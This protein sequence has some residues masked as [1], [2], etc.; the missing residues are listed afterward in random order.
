M[1][2]VAYNS[3]LKNGLFSIL[4]GSY[5]STSNVNMLSYRTWNPVIS[6]TV[7]LNWAVYRDFYTTANSSAVRL[8]LKIN[9]IIVSSERINDNAPNTRSQIPRTFQNVDFTFP[10]FIAKPGH[11]YQA[12]LELL[13]SPIK[14]GTAY[15]ARGNLYYD[16]SV[17]RNKYRFRYDNPHIRNIN[18]GI[19][20]I[21]DSDYWYGGIT[22]HAPPNEQDDPCKMVYREGLW[23]L[24]TPDEYNSLIG[25]TDPKVIRRNQLRNEGWYISWDNASNIGAPR[26]PHGHLI[27]TALGNKDANGYLQMFDYK[28]GNTVTTTWWPFGERPEYGDT[29]YFRTSGINNYFVMNYRRSTGNTNLRLLVSTNR[30]NIA[31][32]IRCVR[33]VAP[34]LS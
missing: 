30:N 22:P 21:G 15:W 34:N 16:E 13:E 24:P 4:N 17:D 23:R 7:P 26:H 20:N 5:S 19:H 29:G 8:S 32:P 3:G 9:E 2:V 10:D 14:R 12:L 25:S 28:A 1:D 33:K 27:F 18:N 6:D 11:R 31:A